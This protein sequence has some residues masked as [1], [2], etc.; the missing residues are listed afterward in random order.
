M[1]SFFVVALLACLAFPAA[2]DTEY[3]PCLMAQDQQQQQNCCKANKGICG[4]R[5]GKIVCCDKTFAEG[6]TC[7]R[8]DEDKLASQ[9]Q[10]I[11]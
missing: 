1:K 4:C 5:A 3:A 11:S 6:C 7:A 10:P 8:E 2:G 9:K